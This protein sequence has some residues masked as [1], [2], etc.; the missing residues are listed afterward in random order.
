MKYKIGDTVVLK[1]DMKPYIVIALAPSLFDD[2]IGL[3]VSR[4]GGD[5]MSINIKE[6][7]V[8]EV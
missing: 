7:D 4:G 1:E 2:D 5:K 6:S 3:I 8:Y